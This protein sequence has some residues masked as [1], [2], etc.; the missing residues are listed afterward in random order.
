MRRWFQ[1]H[2]AVSLEKLIEN[3]LENLFNRFEEP[4]SMVRWDSPLFTVFPEDTLPGPE[5]IEAVTNSNLKPPNAGTLSVCFRL[6]F[7]SFP[8]QCLVYNPDGESSHRCIIC[9]GKNDRITCI[10]DHVRASTEQWRRSGPS[11]VA[12]IFLSVTFCAA[13]SPSHT[14]RAAAVKTAVCVCSQKGM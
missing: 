4:S 11:V 2:P 8:I 10:L 12:W 5:I 6:S 7:S 9:I 13:K 14:I 3:R 1:F